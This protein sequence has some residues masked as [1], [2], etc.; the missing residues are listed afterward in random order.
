MES[1]TEGQ[2]IN[3]KTN[4]ALTME[5]LRWV[6]ITRGQTVLDV[7][8]AAGTTTRLMA[9][10]VGKYGKSVGV[11]LSEERI[12]EA[13]L[14]SLNLSQTE[15]R[16]GNAENIPADNSE[17]DV[18]WSRFLFE[19]L[20]N[21]MPVIAEMIRVTKLN[22]KVLISDLDGN[23]L[24]HS[25]IS[26]T[27]SNELN[28]AINLLNQYGFDPFVGRKLYGLAHQAGLKNIEVD[29]KPYHFIVGKINEEIELHWQMKLETVSKT[30]IKLGWESERA[31]V[32]K[33]SFLNHLRDESTFTYSTII[34]VKGIKK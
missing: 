1:K 24:W 3:L 11:D 29:I 4:V 18:T 30:L 23:C 27:F 25:P 21:P 9:E 12:N 26:Q 6:G 28:E 7:G 8:C 19:Y 16:V 5:Q 34:T 20:K 13:K 33:D 14:Y 32:L 15:Y 2:R 17:F 22:G 31:E 10:L